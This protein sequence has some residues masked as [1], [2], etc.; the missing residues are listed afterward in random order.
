MALFYTCQEAMREEH[1]GHPVTYR[2][3]IFDPIINKYDTL[4]HVFEPGR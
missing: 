3:T 2:I 4:E 1:S